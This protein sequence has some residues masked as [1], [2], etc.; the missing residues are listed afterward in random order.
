MNPYLIVIA[1]VIWLATLTFFYRNQIWLP[2]YL[3]GAIGCAF[4]VIYLGQSTIPIESPLEGLIAAQIDF[5]CRLIGIPT[6]LF[7]GAPGFLVVL[8]VS[9]PIGWTSVQITI[10]CSGLLESAV[11]VGM[12]GFYPGLSLPRKLHLGLVGLLLTQLANLI[13]LLFIV[14]TLHFLGKDA[15]FIAHTI[16]GRLV[17]FAAIVLIYWHVLTAPTLST[18]RTKLQRELMA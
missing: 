8:V 11:L 6:R 3:V 5:L 2:Y 12:L 15:L 7:E 14:A 1:I 18:I 4:G 16:V 13:R 17:F 9:Q 10:E